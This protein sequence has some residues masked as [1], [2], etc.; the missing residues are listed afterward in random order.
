LGA[1]W[2]ET[3]SSSSIAG[4]LNFPEAS[5]AISGQGGIPLPADSGSRKEDKR[6]EDERKALLTI[7]ADAAGYFRKELEGSAGSAA[8]PI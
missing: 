4:R 8:G 1:V 7:I 6:N 2:V 5:E 3:R